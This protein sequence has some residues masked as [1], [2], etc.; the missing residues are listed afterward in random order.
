M[1]MNTQTLSMEP[2]LAQDPFATVFWKIDGKLRED[3]DYLDAITYGATPI[4]TLKRYRT[5][6]DF[7]FCELLGGAWKQR[8]IRFYRD[9]GPILA[10]C[11]TRDEIERYQAVLLIALDVPLINYLVK[12][13]LRWCRF[14]SVVLNSA[15]HSGIQIPNPKLPNSNRHTAATS[16]A[17]SPTVTSKPD[18]QKEWRDGRDGKRF[19]R[20]RIR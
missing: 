3:G 18:P 1:C 17:A 6:I 2:D 4:T 10:K 15:R 14:R 12:R 8:C 7:L 5:I 11:L 9:E 16:K 19:M 20:R 13:R